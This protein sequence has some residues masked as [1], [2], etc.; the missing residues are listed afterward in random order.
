MWIW[1]GYVV[2]GM[3]LQI[4]C[5]KKGKVIIVKINDFVNPMILFKRL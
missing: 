1:K 4:K 2:A 3:T 5:T